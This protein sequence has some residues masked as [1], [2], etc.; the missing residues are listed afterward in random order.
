MINDNMPLEVRPNTLINFRRDL[1]YKSLDDGFQLSTKFKTF[2]F[3]HD[4]SFKE[5][6]EVV[7]KGGKTAEEIVSIFD[8]RGVASDWTLYYL[9]LM[10]E[11]GV[12]DEEPQLKDS[13]V[14]VHK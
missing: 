12:L 13:K 8:S 14:L 2:K 1:K 9:N 7:N 10:F 4:Y 5:F 11:K 3:R 6:G